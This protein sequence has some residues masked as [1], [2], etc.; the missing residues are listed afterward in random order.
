MV[1]FTVGAKSTRQSQPLLIKVGAKST[2]H[3]DGCN[4]YYNK[5]L[6]PHADNIVNNG[7]AWKMPSCMCQLCKKSEVCCGT[8]GRCGDG[9]KLRRIAGE[10]RNMTEN[11]LSILIV[12]FSVQLQQTEISERKLFISH[13]GYGAFRQP[14][15]ECGCCK[16]QV[17]RVYGLRQNFYVY[18]LYRNSDLDD[19]IIDSLPASMAAMQAEAWG[20]PCLFPVCWWFEILNGHHQVWLGSTT[21][22]RHGVAAFDFTTVSGCDLFVV[23]PTHACGGI[24]DLLMTD[25]APMGNSNHS[26]PRLSVGSHFDGSGSSKPVCE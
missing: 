12:I 22:N 23:G 6:C 21:T 20:C 15:L 3:H 9:W 1:S 19:W 7:V 4:I 24:L 2:R 16:M 25:V 13:L 18:S 26:S 17:F 11:A 8:V 14:K 10:A 5:R